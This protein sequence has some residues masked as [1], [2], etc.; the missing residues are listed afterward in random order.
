M[1]TDNI[2]TDQMQVC[3]PVFLKL[4]S[5]VSVAVI[6]DTG[7]IVGQRIQ[8]YIGNMLWIERYRNTPVKGSS[9]YT[10]IL[11]SWKKEV[12]HHLILSG[13]RLDKLWMRINV[14]DQLRCIFAHTEEICL[15]LCRLNL[16]AAV[17]ALA[18][19]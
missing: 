12:V 7:N 13:N 1:E 18:V 2:L 10:Q 17:R 16:S 5:A 4:V 19:Y 3:R 14:L 11:K 9:G 6:A 15:F 8:P